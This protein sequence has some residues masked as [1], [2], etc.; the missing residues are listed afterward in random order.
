MWGVI[1]ELRQTSGVPEEISL[2]I[3]KEHAHIRLEKQKKYSNHK[4]NNIKRTLKNLIHKMKVNLN[5]NLHF[6]FLY[7]LVLG[8]KILS[9]AS[10]AQKASFLNCMSDL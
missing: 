1:W 9:H 6:Q 7:Y 10:R 2:L 8:L 3:I 5:S 4:M